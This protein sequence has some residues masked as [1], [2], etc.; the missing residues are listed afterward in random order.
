MWRLE[1]VIKC[2]WSIPVLLGW[3]SLI[4]ELSSDAVVVILPLYFLPQVGRYLL[5]C[6]WGF[7]CG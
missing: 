2:D 6:V 5:G 7:E 3:L 4:L 1:V